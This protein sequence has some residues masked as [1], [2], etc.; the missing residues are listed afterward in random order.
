ME[1][2]YYWYSLTDHP[3]ILCS[4]SNISGL[5]KWVLLLLEF[6]RLST[7]FQKV[8]IPPRLGLISW[9]TPGETTYPIISENLIL[10]NILHQPLSPILIPWLFLCEE[11]G[12]T[13]CTSI[14]LSTHTTTITM[15]R[16]ALAQT[17]TPTRTFILTTIPYDPDWSC[18][19][20]WARQWTG[21]FWFHWLVIISMGYRPSFDQVFH[22]WASPMR[23]LP[24]L[25]IFCLMPGREIIL[26]MSP[27]NMISALA[28]PCS[29]SSIV[30]PYPSPPKSS[31]VS[32]RP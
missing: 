5:I 32:T 2:V 31:I 26:K 8:L 4:L 29:F 22:L 11:P 12:Y 1:V 21:S 24:N 6:Y 18:Q 14:L 13:M 9:C 10:T 30:N 19:P 20:L 25:Y 3:L 17:T 15:G 28:S 16:A 7:H 27:L 23:E